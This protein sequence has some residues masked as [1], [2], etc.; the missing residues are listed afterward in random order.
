MT[1]NTTVYQVPHSMSFSHQVLQI[2]AFGI[3]GTEFVCARCPSCHNL[4]KVAEHWHVCNLSSHKITLYCNTSSSPVAECL[5][6][7]TAIFSWWT[8]VSRYQNV[9]ILNFIGTKDCGDRGGGSNWSCKTCKAPVKSSPPTNQH[10][11]F[12][13]FTSCCPTNSIRPLKGKELKGNCNS[14]RSTI[15]NCSYVMYFKWFNGRQVTY[16]EKT[17][18]KSL[19]EI[20]LNSFVFWVCWL[21][22]QMQN[23]MRGCFSVQRLAAYLLKD[24]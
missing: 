20:N 11:A 4:P 6:I 10:P 12:Y 22:I 1:V 17:V 18:K 21:G 2:R 14:V 19:N 3:A 7:L 8:W 5:S 23:S 24:L 16:H 15:I 13:L 9:S